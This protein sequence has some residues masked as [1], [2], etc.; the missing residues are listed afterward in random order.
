MA[1]ETLNDETRKFILEGPRDNPKYKPRRRLGMREALTRT[2]KPAAATF[3]RFAA[4]HAP[5]GYYLKNKSHKLDCDECWHCGSGQQQTR[6]H[7]MLKCTT[8]REERKL[9]WKRL[10]EKAKSRKGWKRRWSLREVFSKDE[11]VE[12]IIEFFENTGIGKE[13]GGGRRYHAP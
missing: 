11:W 8:F 3:L 4:D 5:T 13:W 9:L 7:L 6:S 10:A 2:R 12:D 1:T